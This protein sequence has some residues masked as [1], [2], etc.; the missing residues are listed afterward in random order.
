M[1]QQV[2]TCRDILIQISCMQ[3]VVSLKNSKNFIIHTH[4][5]CLLLH[6]EYWRS[7]WDSRKLLL[8][9][10]SNDPLYHG[11]A[12]PERS[13][14]CQ[15]TWKKY[16]II[17]TLSSSRNNSRWFHTFPI[18]TLLAYIYSILIHRSISA[19]L[20]TACSA[21]NIVCVPFTSINQHLH[22]KNVFHFASGPA[23][24]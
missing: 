23:C 1:V 14:G 5:V 4:V 12:N 21:I 15:W 19:S 6:I 17:I 2:S 11:W 24:C 20:P 9:V 18:S 7:L 3:L 16:L 8:P 13:T 10:T 22:E